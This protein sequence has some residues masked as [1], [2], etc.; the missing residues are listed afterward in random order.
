NS[1]LLAG[2]DPVIVVTGYRENE[3]IDRLTDWPVQ[4]IGGANPDWPMSDSVRRAIEAVG[5][6]TSGAKPAETTP[7]VLVLPGDHPAVDPD[8]IRTL[9]EAH[10]SHPGTIHLPVF[11]GRSGH[12]ALFP[13]EAFA[14]LA[15]PD[16]DLGLR[17]LLHNGPF[18]VIR[19]RIDDPGI[20]R[21]LDTPADYT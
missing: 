10:E 3:I 9:I 20:M 14:A 7:A 6:D 15:T 16:P 17:A 1:L 13:P 5:R 2:C 12:P 4:I 11:A 21:N 18:P 8:A 19:H